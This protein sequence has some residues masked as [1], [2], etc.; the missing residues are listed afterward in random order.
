MNIR[1]LGGAALL[2]LAALFAGSASAEAGHR[3]GRDCGHRGYSSSRGY[4]SYDRGYYGRGHRSY[5]H[6]YSYRAPRRH[7]SV[8]PYYSG[9]SYYSGRPY[10]DDYGYD[11]Y[12]SAPP[13]YYYGRR[14]CRPR[15]RVGVFFGF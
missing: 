9:R 13:D 8:R 2:G 14:H 1:K 15:S 7:Y 5:R 10:D 6:G 11:S 4:D 12:Y 3:H